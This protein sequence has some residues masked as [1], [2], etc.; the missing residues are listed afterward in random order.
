MCNFVLWAVNAHA[1]DQDFVDATARQLGVAPEPSELRLK[2]S[3]VRANARYFTLTPNMC[4]CGSL[5]GLGD[6]ADPTDGIE[7]PA[8]L[9]WLARMPDVAPRIT[10]L[11]LYSAW[12]PEDDPITPARAKGIKA[13]QLDEPL[14]RRLPEDLL[15]TIDYPAR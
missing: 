6:T 12:S 15:L 3:R 2:S 14:L 9:S 8:L 13:A 5:V 10:R 11:A 7:T 1:F 4:N